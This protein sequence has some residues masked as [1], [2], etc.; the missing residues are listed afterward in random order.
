MATNCP[1]LKN[2]SQSGERTGPD[3]SGTRFGPGHFAMARAGNSA[4]IP[5]VARCRLRTRSCVQSPRRQGII[6]RTSWPCLPASPA[7]AHR[8]KE[9]A[10]RVAVFVLVGLGLCSALLPAA[11]A[12]EK[13]L[14]QPPEG[15]T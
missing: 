3:D 5:A 9:P 7:Y 15:F 1:S 6:T 14:N 4:W 10:M 8:F 2:Q 11:G 12:A 13:G